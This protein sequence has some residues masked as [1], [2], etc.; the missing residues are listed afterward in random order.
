MV[1]NLKI[2]DKTYLFTEEL[3]SIQGIIAR[4]SSHSFLI[5]GWA[6]SLVFINFLFNAKGSQMLLA[7]FPLV[8]FWYLDAFFTREVRMFKALHRWVSS[9]R[10]KTD[11]HFFDLSPET[12]FEKKV[13]SILS[14]MF[15]PQIFYLYGIMFLLIWGYFLID[16]CF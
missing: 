7:L 8:V 6:V 5:K 3:S 10:L 1:N 2:S 11:D 4:K 14:L 9:N 13:P 15:S 16:Y 12:R